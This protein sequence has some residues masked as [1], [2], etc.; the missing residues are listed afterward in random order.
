MKSVFSNKKTKILGIVVVISTLLIVFQNCSPMEAAKPEEQ[1]HYGLLEV[2][3]Q[4]I[5]EDE[6]HLES[7]V[8]EQ[9]NVQKNF[10][11]ISNEGGE[12]NGGPANAHATPSPIAS[13][14]NVN[15]LPNDN[16]SNYVAGQFEDPTH[17]QNPVVE[18]ATSKDLY[19]SPQH[20]NVASNP[21]SPNAD[22]NFD[23][24]QVFGGNSQQWGKYSGGSNAHAL[25]RG[26]KYYVFEIMFEANGPAVSSGIYFNEGM[27]V[28]YYTISSCPGDFRK[29]DNNVKC[30][31]VEQ[32]GV[33]FLTGS[34][35]I[36][37]STTLPMNPNDPFGNVDYSCK[38][39]VGK[40]Y[41]LN[42]LTTQTIT[43]E[44]LGL[45]NFS[46][47]YS[48]QPFAVKNSWAEPGSFFNWE[49]SWEKLT[50]VQWVHSD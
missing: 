28:P 21:I 11:S 3:K 43:G 45:P 32:N 26:S 13:S 46:S 22:G 20:D 27:Y 23:L 49:P 36:G 34:R 44:T 2:F 12:S 19:V 9:R 14:S 47:L 41:Y 4:L 38:L 15:Y 7:Y 35:R 25:L 1:P 31:S 37:Q 50:Y 16:C 39:E 17:E 18:K 48:G 10:E 42:V 33:P 24:K 30:R 6:A 40:K 5:T 29:S 8:Q